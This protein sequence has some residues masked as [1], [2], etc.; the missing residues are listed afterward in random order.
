MNQIVPTREGPDFICVG[1]QKGGTQW[2]F[3]QLDGH[4]DFWMPPI[5]EL[6]YFDHPGGHVKKA[7]RLL[8]AAEDDLETCNATRVQQRRRPLT[9]GDILH[10]R[11]YVR[12]TKKIRMKE[13]ASLFSMKD[14]RLSG[15][16]TP[17]YS[18]LK[19]GLAQRIVERFP[20]ARIVFIAREPI[21]RFW[22]AYNMDLR[23]LGEEPS[24]ASMMAYFHRDG[25][26]R[27]TFQ[28]EA[29]RRW[30][31]ITPNGRFALFF[32]DDLIANAVA[33]R[34]TILAFLGGDPDKPSADFDPDYNRK[35]TDLKI[36]MTDDYRSRLIELFADDIRA[37]AAEFG[38][39]A[40][41]WPARYQL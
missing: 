10:L 34:E 12:R 23:R 39:P 31:R 27:R 5:K 19:P 18:A 40:L 32:F 30:R 41:D 28:A 3:D 15:D 11:I 1:T 29:V 16:I 35:G 9:E 17:N 6:H 37:C 7:S 26:Q 2:L 21:E 8:E 13:Y 33:F 38:G 24:V 14:K 20:D 22:S 4:P 25:V 36:P